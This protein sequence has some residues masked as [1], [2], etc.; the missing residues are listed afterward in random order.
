MMNKI[1]SLTKVLCKEHFEK[2]KTYNKKNIFFW[3]AILLNITLGYV[4]YEILQFLNKF[5]Q[6]EI[7]LNI[8][9]FIINNIIIFE[10]IL[11]APSIF[12]YSK[13]LEFILPFPFK[14]IELLLSKFNTVLS[15]SYFTEILFATVPLIIYGLI[16]SQ[17]LLY[18]FWM[19]IILLIFPIIPT[20]VISTFF[21]FLIKL[22]KFIKNKDIFQ[23]L[24]TTLFIS[25]FFIGEIQIISNNFTSEEIIERIG[26][27]TSSSIIN[28]NTNNNLKIEDITEQISSDNEKQTTKE[29][30]NN[31]KFHKINRYFL[32]LNPSIELLINY[33]VFIN[34]LKIIIF[35]F[36]FLIL[37][38]LFGNKLYLKNII[39]NLSVISTQKITKHLKKYSFKKIN[40][41]IS[42]IK[43]EFKTLI[44]NPTF[45]MQCIF[46][47]IIFLIIISLLIILIFPVFLE[48]LKSDEFEN[49]EIK[50]DAFWLIIILIIIQIIFTFSNMSLT[51]V[52]R[53]GK[54]ATFMKYIPISLYE[55]FLFMN[56]PQIS[57][58]LFSIL[59]VILIM[60]YLNININLIYLFL[61]F[62]LGNLLNLINSF[63]LLSVDFLKPNINW[64]SESLAIKQNENKLFQYVLT[65]IIILLLIYFKKVF[66]D[67][68]FNIFILILFI[69]LSFILFIINLFILKNIN[70]LF[71]KIN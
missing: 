41:N 48:I 67:L 44:K 58:N 29:L 17:N 20:L 27:L 23:L 16:S 47:S 38:I 32:I 62:I 21:L 57:F 10:T 34:L 53:K 13:D 63:I 71:N 1:I 55:Q 4:S 56:I 45:F 31:N 65:I 12:Y 36:I 68:N 43:N 42:Y 59:I 40:K 46:P 6:G 25:I 11:S 50:F 5:N 60:K 70:K 49:I 64:T 51:A 7:F 24:V 69:F 18:F 35:N 3:L 19:I 28:S 33:N 26:N 22:S 15:I 54:N 14:P 61:I 9:L 8:F 30:L 66:A 37:F 39:K 52:T 2:L